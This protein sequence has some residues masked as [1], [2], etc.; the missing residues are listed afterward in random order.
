M[1]VS[2]LEK[3][4]KGVTGELNSSLD[5]TPIPIQACL[6]KTVDTVALHTATISGME[7]GLSAHSDVACHGRP[8][9]T[10]QMTEPPCD[11]HP[12]RNGGR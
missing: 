4:C 6:Q 1:L 7:K 2:E 8:G 11:W 10:F 3:L 5:P 9:V 12:R